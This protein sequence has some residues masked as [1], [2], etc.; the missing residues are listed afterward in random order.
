MRISIGRRILGVWFGVSF[1]PGG[2]RRRRRTRYWSHPGC[3][4]H[5]QR[6]DTAEACARRMGEVR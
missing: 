2:R 6:Q 4:V 3:A 5:H 1:R